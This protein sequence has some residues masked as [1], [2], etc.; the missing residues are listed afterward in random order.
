MEHRTRGDLELEL[1][2]IRSSPAQ[3][4]VVELIVRRPA[5]DEREIL[6]EATIDPD[7]GIVGDTWPV[8]ASTSSPDGG[9]HPDAQI[10]VTN[11]RVIAAL[12]QIPERWAL[13]GDQL[14]VDF[15]LSITNL[16]AG[17]QLAVGSAVLEVSTTPHLGCVKFRARYG[18]DALTFVNSPVGRELRLR[19]V[20]TKVVKGGTV[21]RGDAI[22][23]MD[24]AG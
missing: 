19:G 17:T 11:A 22:R 14:Y 24:G 21:R 8:R 5:V 10:T 6:D 15:D 4:G 3:R 16:P 13:A 23:R 2:T 1:D 20:N 7:V 18:A 12:A 9:P